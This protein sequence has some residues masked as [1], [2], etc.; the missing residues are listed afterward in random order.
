[1]GHSRNLDLKVNLAGLILAA[2]PSTRLGRPKQ[3][4]V[5]REKTLIE[6]VVTLA[7]EF[8]GAGVVV[9]TGSCH[10]QVFAELQGTTAE[11]VYNPE[12]RNG[13]SSSIRAGLPHIDSACAGV[14][15]MLCDQPAVSRADYRALVEF[16]ISHPDCIVAA[17]YGGTRGVPAIFPATYR[18][19]LMSLNG[20]EG[21]RSIIASA[22][23]VSFVKL[24]NAQFDIDTPDDLRHLDT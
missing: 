13:M 3:L 6:R 11:T 10:N 17:E 15:L 22:E 21:G 24:P 2:G 9:V 1:M 23:R 20:D 8:C 14:M 19:E 7:A 16:W 4:L 12:W 18:D 5:H